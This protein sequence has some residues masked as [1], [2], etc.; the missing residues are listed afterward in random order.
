MSIK[1]QRRANVMG[2]VVISGQVLATG[3]LAFS[4]Y[5]VEPRW[6]A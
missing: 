6:E 5:T 3:L 2:G 1:L 4:T